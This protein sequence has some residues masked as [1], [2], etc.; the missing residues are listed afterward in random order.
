MAGP[1]AGLK[2][3]E[4][5]GIGPG[6]FAAMMLADHGAQVLRVERPGGVASPG[7]PPA[8]ER[9]ALLR[10]RPAVTLDLKSQTDRDLALRLLARAD[11]MIEGLRPGAM[12]R[13]GLG[14]AECLAA[15]PKLVY[16][17]MTGWGQD[18]PLA[19]T[20]GHDL[21]Y[22]ALTGALH[23]MGEPDRPP[24]PPLNLLGDFGGGGMM[25][26]FGILAAVLAARGGAPGQVVDAA[27]T[28]GAASLATMICA[29]REMGAWSDARGANML[30]GGAPYYR[31]YACA[32]GRWIAVGALE[33]QFY[34][35]LAERTGV[36]EFDDAARRDP[37]N[38]PA[39]AGRFAEV[40]AGA[41]RDHWAALFERTDGCVAPVL[42]FA[43][44][45]AHPHNA[46]R[47]TYVAPGGRPQ[48]APAPRFSAT[49][50]AAPEAPAALD[51]D[52]A[53]VLAAWGVSEG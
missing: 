17:R 21:T 27:I 36:V 37:A 34:A 7:V 25:L 23:A 28:D 11:A 18:G 38:W 48:P 4:F 30:D 53:A 3:V 8:R 22:I 13:L 46:A 1:L 10:G 33:P 5:A 50:S 2:I 31:C 32:D 14:P 47:G 44:A 52:R 49:P 43:E 39:L 42:S 40:F 24:P 35:I 26:A 45:P 20:A 19:K 9:D 51:G 6:P 16:G 41:P 12:E 15:N 29:F